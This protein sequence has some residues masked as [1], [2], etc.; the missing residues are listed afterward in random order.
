MNNIII[1]GDLH[2]RQ[3]KKA[4]FNGHGCKRHCPCEWCRANR[5]YKFKHQEPA[6][7]NNDYNIYSNK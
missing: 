1:F 4:K 6:K 7:D 3:F 2:V 5:L